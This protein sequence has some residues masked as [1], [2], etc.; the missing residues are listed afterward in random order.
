VIVTGGMLRRSDGGIVGEAP[1]SSSRS[2][3]SIGRDRRLGHRRRRLLSTSTSGGLAA[4]HHQECAH[5]ILVADA[6]VR[7]TAPVRSAISEVDTFV[8]DRP[9]QGHRELCA[10]MA[11]P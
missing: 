8:T 10:T 1:S 4:C 9:P 5:V 2:S 11:S 3:R 7:P 6:T